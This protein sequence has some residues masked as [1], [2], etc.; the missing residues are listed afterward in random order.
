MSALCQG[1]LKSF[2]SGADK[3]REW[4]ALGV[5]FLVSFMYN[6]ED[7]SLQTSVH[8]CLTFEAYQL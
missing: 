5:R 1:G 8:V 4:Q 7:E 6:V 3:V 2:A